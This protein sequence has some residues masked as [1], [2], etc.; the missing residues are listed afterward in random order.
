MRSEFI[1]VILATACLFSAGCKLIREI[2]PPEDYFSPAS[3][4]ISLEEAE[5]AALA[6]THPYSGDYAAEIAFEH[7]PRG[8]S[9]TTS[10][11]GM[12]ACTDGSHLVY[13]SDLHGPFKVFGGGSVGKGGIVLDVY[14][15]PEDLPVAKQVSCT[16]SITRRDEAL[17]ELGDAWFVIQKRSDL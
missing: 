15:V 16:I 7:V 5:Q 6:V 2:F 3:T 8:L 17:D 9:L 13:H 14:S 10:L 12:I 11:Q 4:R 1:L